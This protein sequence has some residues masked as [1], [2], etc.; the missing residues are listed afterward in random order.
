MA[1]RYNRCLCHAVENSDPPKAAVTCRHLLSFCP[2]TRASGTLDGTIYRGSCPRREP[3]GVIIIIITF[4]PPAHTRRYTGAHGQKFSGDFIVETSRR[5]KLQNAYHDNAAGKTIFARL[6]HRAPSSVFS[7]FTTRTAP[8]SV[9]FRRT[10][11][12]VRGDV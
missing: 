11:V 5:H 6:L 2:S 7:A 1:H 12:D 8:S 3:F 4:L 9:R 10:P